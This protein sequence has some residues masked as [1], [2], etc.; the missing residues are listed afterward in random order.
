[1]SKKFESNRD[2]ILRISAELFAKS[3]YHGTGI[4]D[5]GAA[6]GLGRGALYHYIGSKETI[7]YEISSRQLAQ[8][9]KVADDLAVTETDPEER[10]RGLARALLRNIAEHRAEWTVFFR[11]YHALTGERRDRVIAARER[12]EAHWRNALDQ[13]VRERRFRPLPTLM[14]KGLLGMF[15]YS[16]LWLTL[17]GPES[18]EDIA[19]EFLD[20]VLAGMNAEA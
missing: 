7:L 5:L 4:S 11:E 12:Y 2:E 17:D 1:M 9:N 19:D 10:L 15:N 8:M 14:V 6:V 18:P 13:G 3:G 16:Y 20:T